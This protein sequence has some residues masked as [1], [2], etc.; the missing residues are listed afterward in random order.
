MNN[1][2]DK[3]EA[4]TAELVRTSGDT[5][6][7][8]GK[9]LDVMASR[10]SGPGHFGVSDGSNLAN[11]K[12]GLEAFF[13]TVTALAETLGVALAQ[14]A[15]RTVGLGAGS[16]SGAAGASDD[17]AVSK[18]ALMDRVDANADDTEKKANQLDPGQNIEATPTSG[19]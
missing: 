12:A 8:T 6:T 17:G 9:A 14:V 3:L 13:T 11:I 18:T 16:S 7:E 5:A 2:M 1:G 15:Q 19:K 10:K 4:D